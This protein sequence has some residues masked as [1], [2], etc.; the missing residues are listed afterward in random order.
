LLALAAGY[1]LGAIPTGYVV[2]RAWGVDV[3]QHGSGRTGGTNVYRATKQVLP[4]ILTILGDVLKGAAA[5]LIGRYLLHSE[6]AAALAGAASLFGHNWSLVLGWR[7]GAGGMTAGAALVFLSPVA[8]AIVA[9]AALL[10]LY[11]S[12]YASVATL[13]VGLGSLVVLTLLAWLAG[14]GH[15]WAHV[16][17]GALVAA[18]I[19][20]GLR[21]NLK[22]LATG[23]ERRITHW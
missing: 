9:V 21:P 3:R 15:P 23:T 20:W 16:P 22:R 19:V 6:L 17:F 12:R 8:G 18:G 1:L 10:L 5:V 7:G 2:G 4:L 13:V 11:I 14:S